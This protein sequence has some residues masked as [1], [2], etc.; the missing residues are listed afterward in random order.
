MTKIFFVCTHNL[1]EN[2]LYLY[3]IEC[4]RIYEFYQFKMPAEHV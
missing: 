4:K 3:Q 1:G 2:S